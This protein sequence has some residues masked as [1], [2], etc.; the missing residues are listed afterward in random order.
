MG[1]EM[2]T[3]KEAAAVLRVTPET[4]RRWVKA[5]LVPAVRIGEHTVRIPVSAIRRTP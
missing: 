2:L 4:V 1:D 5:G 3:P